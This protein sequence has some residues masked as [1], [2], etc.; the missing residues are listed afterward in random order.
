LKSRDIDKKC[1]E[2]ADTAKHLYPV[3]QG[4]PEQEQKRVRRC[5]KRMN[6]LLNEEVKSLGS[7]H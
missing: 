4:G 5:P 7:L 2:G 3:E 1:K 6:Q